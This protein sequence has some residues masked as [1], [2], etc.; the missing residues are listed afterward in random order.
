MYTVT[1]TYIGIVCQSVHCLCIP[2]YLTNDI[3]STGWKWAEDLCD[4]CS[5]PCY[6]MYVTMYVRLCTVS[7]YT[8]VCTSTNSTM[9]GICHQ[10]CTC[11]MTSDQ[12]ITLYVQFAVL[13]QKHTAHLHYHNNMYRIDPRPSPIGQ[14]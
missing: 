8:Y 5:G 1:H 11:T 6:C 12:C 4:L 10:Q 3:Y 2:Q 9:K 7:L 13:Y 14:H